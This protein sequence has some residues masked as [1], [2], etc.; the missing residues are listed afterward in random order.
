VSTLVPAQLF[1]LA[2]SL[3]Q[4]ARLLRADRSIGAPVDH[5]QRPARERTHG[6]P[7]IGDRSNQRGEWSVFGKIA[8]GGERDGAHERIVG[9]DNDGE[10]RTERISG[11]RD[12]PRIDTGLAGEVIDRAIRLA[13]REP[14]LLNDGEGIVQR[15][16]F[17]SSFTRAMEREIDG[18]TGNT[19]PEEC[20]A[21]RIRDLLLS[22]AEAVEQEHCGHP[23]AARWQLKNGWYVLAAATIELEYMPNVSRL[24]HVG[25]HRRY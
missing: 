1:R 8:T 5:E 18:E 12:V 24:R 19:M 9:G 23:S 14:P 10:V 17:Y 20:S 6:S 21:D 25:I 15:Q 7:R 16:P 3:E 2:S 22:R 13:H 11:D 4:R